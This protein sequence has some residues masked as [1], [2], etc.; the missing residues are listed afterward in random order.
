[1]FTC[2]GSVHA[3]GARRR[4]KAAKGAQRRKHCARTCATEWHSAA[5]ARDGAYHVRLLDVDDAEHLDEVRARVREEVLHLRNGMVHYMW[6]QPCLLHVAT[7]PAARCNL[8]RCTLQPCPLHVAAMSGA[9]FFLTV[10]TVR[11]RGRAKSQCRCG[12]EGE[13]SHLEICFDLVEL[14]DLSTKA[15]TS[16]R[17]YYSLYSTLNPHC[18]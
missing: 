8:A 2:N 9:H 6:Y 15:Q 12:R 13:G 5:A 11:G 17:C 16:G 10:Q 4:S 14:F 1:M 3:D 18:I 7:L